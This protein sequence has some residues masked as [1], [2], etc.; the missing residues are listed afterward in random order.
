MIFFSYLN[1]LHATL[2]VIEPNELIILR[3]VPMQACCNLYRPCCL[4]SFVETVHMKCAY[5]TD[6]ACTEETAYSI[7]FIVNESVVLLRMPYYH[8]YDCTYVNIASVKAFLLLM[9]EQ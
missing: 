8:V 6:A 1:R 4:R 5:M 2:S 7:V 3:Q 9:R